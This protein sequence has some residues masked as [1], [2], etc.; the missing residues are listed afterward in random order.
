MLVNIFLTL[1]IL[2]KELL[3]ENEDELCLIIFRHTV[4]RI[5]GRLIQNN[6]KLECIN[7]IPTTHQ[8]LPG[9]STVLTSTTLNRLQKQDGSIVLESSRNI[10]PNR[11]HF[12][13]I[14]T[15]TVANIESYGK[16]Q[17]P[18]AQYSAKI[19]QRGVIKRGYLS[20]TSEN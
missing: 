12:H 5:D 13:T 15:S 7:L 6:Q 4:P 17:Q 1:W 10:R 18:L 11:N 3:Y 9:K 19:I 2:Y 8:T 16:K 20:P 14:A